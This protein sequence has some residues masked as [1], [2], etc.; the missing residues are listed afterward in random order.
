MQGTS[1]AHALASRACAW[2]GTL[3]F[4][5]S[6]S[7]F[8]VSYGI[9][10]AE[11][12]PPGATAAPIA[13]NTLL[14][15]LFAVHHSVFA[16]ARVRMWVARVVPPALERSVYVWVASMLFIA[17]CALWQ[18]VPGRAWNVAGPA[19]W[20]L[21]VVQGACVWLILRSAA[22][23]DVLELSGVRQLSPEPRTT[24]FRTSGPYGWMRHPIYAGWILLVF[25]APTMTMTRFVFAFV[26]SI[27]LLIAIPLE[28][29][30]MLAS[31]GE[32]YNAY[33]RQV[34]WRLLPGIY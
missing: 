31:A 20:L 26:S 12:A 2:G 30:S 8:L 17:V 25:C 14:F 27:Y 29:R 9:T 23:L 21:V 28:E 18:P 33:I 7:F 22:A 3:L 5:A 13:V 24:E 34:R 4:A 15:T 32:A 19:R 1:G 10:F 11:T 6:L 16:R